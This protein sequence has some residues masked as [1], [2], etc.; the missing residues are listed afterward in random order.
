MHRGGGHFIE[1]I[2]GALLILLFTLFMLRATMQITDWANDKVQEIQETITETS[3]RAS[4]L[5]HLAA[6]YSPRASACKSS[7]ASDSVMPTRSAS[8][9]HR[10]PSGCATQEAISRARSVS[11][12]ASRNTVTDSN[13]LTN[14]P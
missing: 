6:S 3:R 12:G 9:A 14:Q 1:A 7:A 4:E 8:Q 11:V 5:E 10:A 2:A 13:T